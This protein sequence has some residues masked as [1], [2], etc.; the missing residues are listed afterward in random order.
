MILEPKTARILIAF[1]MLAPACFAGEYAVLSNGFRI[2]ADRV[3]TV[4]FGPGSD[5]I[6]LTSS[7]DRTAKIYRCGTC[8]PLSR[9]RTLALARERAVH[10]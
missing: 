5:S 2:H 6:I 9:L 7:D 10:G 3:N 8:L 1:A 4:E